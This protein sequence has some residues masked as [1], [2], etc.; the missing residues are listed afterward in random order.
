[1]S[2]ARNRRADL[3]IG[4][5]VGGTNTDAVVLDASD[6]PVAKTKVATTPDINTG[7]R[8]A[9]AA[10]LADP[11]V[12]AA[13]VGHVMIGT[14]HATNALLERRELRRVAALR[15]GAPASTSV[16]PIFG[17]PEDLR[18]AVSAD[19]AVVAGGLELDG[20]DSVAFD[21]DAVARFC[22]E[23]GDR[24]EAIAI[25]SVFAPVSPRHEFLALDVVRRELGDIPVSLSHQVGSLGLLERENTTILNA[26]L[27]R[28]AV[29]VVQ[30]IEDA[31]K[32]H[33]LGHA[34]PYFAQN[35]GTLMSLESTERTPVLTIGS[36]PANSLRGAAFLTGEANALVADVGGTSTDIGALS[37]TF[38]R[39]SAFGVEIGG[40]AT[41][42]R[43]PDL[44]S[45]AIGGGTVVARDG[46]GAVSVGPRSVGYR[47]GE[48]ALVFG[49]EVA[50]LSDAA[51]AAGRA[52][53]GH[54]D[55][56]ASA[57]PLLA[58]AIGESDRRITDAIDRIKVTR[59]DL[60]LIAVGGGSVLIPDGLP[61]VT[62]VIRPEHFDV[63]NAIGAA[64]GTVSGHVDRIVSI[65]RTE[66]ERARVI[67]EARKDAV[68]NAVGAGAD[69]GAVEIVEI[70][71]IP[72]SYLREPAVRLRVKAAGPLSKV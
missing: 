50:T 25:S 39:E 64:I 41:N 59:G 6:R 58:E 61:G 35:D 44:V 24:A 29:Q 2:A 70:D 54:Q 34:V 18:R 47:L 53:M 20:G 27:G 36:G 65:G 51:V 49:G 11:R 69:P 62:E 30:A 72:L 71:E 16:R 46:D 14:T 31:L 21:A 5:D 56:P 42:F 55:V 19:A 7:I 1:M 23:V 43:M 17:W 38:P 9:L 28:V 32:V 33:D 22:A 60:P 26:A 57:H 66:G 63:A 45:I 37:L 12:G 8:R 3:R 68:G 4:I 13:R 40:V 48:R 10:V 15:I 67:E 52:R